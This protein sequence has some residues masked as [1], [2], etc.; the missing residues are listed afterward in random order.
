MK[1]I[2]K[3]KKGL[4]DAKEGK[5]SGPYTSV[6]EMLADMKKR[7]PWNWLDY[8]ESYW[9]RYFW[10]FVSSIPLEV[11]SFIQRGI[12]GYSDRDTWD[13]DTYLTDVIEGGLKHLLKH[14]MLR[15]DKKYVEDL[16]III[17]TMK[18]SRDINNSLKYANKEEW[19]KAQKE[20]RKGMSV[21]TK[22]W[23]ELWD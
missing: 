9:Y 7:N 8:L 22:R 17:K 6:E 23:F 19:K 20:F 21:L 11:R 15:N 5:I 18:L 14:T 2:D 16:K 12:R 1:P 4:Q 3:I 10:N 13:F